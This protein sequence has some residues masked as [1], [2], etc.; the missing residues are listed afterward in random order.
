M[1]HS[2]AIVGAGFGGLMLARVLHVHGIAS[3]VYEAEAVDRRFVEVICGN[4]CWILCLL[5]QFFGTTRLN[6]S[7]HARVV[8]MY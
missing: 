5:E 6:R 1:T 3:T 2:I 8:S 7:C 4:C